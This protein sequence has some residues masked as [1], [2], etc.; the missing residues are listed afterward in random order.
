MSNKTLSKVADPYARALFEIAR[1][2]GQLQEY[3]DDMAVVV[4]VFS[5][6]PDLITFFENPFYEDYIKVGVIMSLFINEDSLSDKNSSQ[7]HIKELNKCVDIIPFLQILMYRRRMSLILPIATRFKELCD[8][9]VGIKDA[10]CFSANALTS[11]QEKELVTALINRTGYKEIR[12]KVYVDR[13]LLGGLQ[14]VIDSNL[15]DVSLRGRL[16]SL[17]EKMAS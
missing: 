14:V 10:F 13:T 9:L 12:L 2:K 6:C 8:E 17:F 5:Q 16:S 15:I 4:E 1:N 11:S 3:L 7:H